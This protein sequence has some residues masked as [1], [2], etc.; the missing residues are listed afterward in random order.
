MGEDY[1]HPIDHPHHAAGGRQG[2]RRLR[3]QLHDLA[4]EI[5][6]VADVSG[7]QLRF[8]GSELVC[9]QA[10]DDCRHAALVTVPAALLRGAFFQVPAN[11]HPR[12]LY[13]R[14]D[15]LIAP[16]AA[17]VVVRLPLG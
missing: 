12:L 1:T 5:M 15:S 8:Q 2:Y 6:I 17:S 14:I 16:K 3:Q 4:S 9:S 11:R 7:Q 10:L 13:S